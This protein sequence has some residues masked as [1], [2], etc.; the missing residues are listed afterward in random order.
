MKSV[1]LKCL[2]LLTL[3]SNL[4][5]TSEEDDGPIV[6]RLSTDSPLIPIYVTPFYR[7]LADFD[8]AYIK[9][10]EEIL[11]FDLSHNGMTYLTDNP[12][13]LGGFDETSDLNHWQGKGVYYVIKLCLDEKSLKGRVMSLNAQAIKQIDGIQ[14]TG[15]INSDRRQIH[16]LADAIHLALFGKEGVA[17]TR[18]LYTVKLKGAQGP[19]SEIW[20]ADYDGKNPRQVVKDFGYCLTPAYIPPKPGNLT[21]GIM[22]VSYKTGQSKIYVAN[23][24]DGKGQRFSY[25][26]GN[27]LMPA[28]STQRDKVAFITDYTGNPDLFLQPFT[29][30]AGAIGKPQQ[31]Y[32]THKATQGTPTFHPNGNQVAFVS[33]KDGAPRIYVMS[34]PK[35]GTNYKD[36][37]PQLI[38]KLNKENSAPTWSPDGTKLAYCSF[39]GGHRQIW[40]YDFAKGQEW[41]LTQGPGNKENPT[42]APNSLHLIFN[43][44]GR[45]G[46]D[47][48][49][50]NL[51]QA[52]SVKI[53]SGIGEKRFP[54][55]EPR[56]IL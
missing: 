49:L 37:K 46:S 22:F 54:N 23:L 25:F 48:Y 6:V 17:S 11:R 13:A 34:I 7:N 14:L 16:Q 29:P 26:R 30:E 35:P 36:L 47:L 55:W 10:L 21:G 28:I 4:G 56:P 33:N 42:W 2:F 18:I 8:S 52:E 31:I 32:A 19:V 20:E 40:I 43:S 41:Q 50:I 24:K 53:S 51:N 12:G 9:Q 44:T 15:E 27:Q 38:T 3:F 5:Y 45:D 39:S 1:I